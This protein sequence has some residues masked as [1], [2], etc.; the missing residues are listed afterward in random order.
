MKT[1]TEDHS[2]YEIPQSRGIPP[3]VR[4][5]FIIGVAVIVFMG[6]ISEYESGYAHIWPAKDTPNVELKGKL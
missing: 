2:P 5:F 1:L 3:V 4:W 6:W